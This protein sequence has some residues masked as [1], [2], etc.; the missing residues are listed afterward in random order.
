MGESRI[1]Y[2]FLLLHSIYTIKEVTGIKSPIQTNYSMLKKMLLMRNVN[3]FRSDNS[4]FFL[5]I[6]VEKCRRSKNNV[7]LVHFRSVTYR[8]SFWLPSK[9]NRLF[10][11][12]IYIPSTN[13][14]TILD[15]I[16][17]SFLMK[18]SG[19]IRE[20]RLQS[21]TQDLVMLDG[22][23]LQFCWGRRVKN[24]HQNLHNELV[25][26]N[27]ILVFAQ[28]FLESQRGKHCNSLE[29]NLWRKVVSTSK[30]PILERDQH[31]RRSF[32]AHY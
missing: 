27:R 17:C 12:T 26:S 5:G 1:W 30:K 11:P 14:S 7:F 31:F 2:I 28:R 15:L 3:I 18:L 32:I 16:I 21:P 19:F 10:G 13:K 25:A 23:E 29:G 4:E 20:R 24:W 6:I 8:V 22:H 9:C